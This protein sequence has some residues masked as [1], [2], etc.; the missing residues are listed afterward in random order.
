MAMFNSYFDITRGYPWT[1][2]PDFFG[3]NLGPKQ[4]HD[5]TGVA[6]GLVSWRQLGLA[7]KCEFLPYSRWIPMAEPSLSLSLS[8]S[9]RM[10]IYI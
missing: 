10:Y 2:S 1:K 5:L 8:L 7:K 6:G 4:N 3:V 9:L